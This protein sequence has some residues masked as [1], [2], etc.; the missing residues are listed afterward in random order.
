MLFTANTK[1]DEDSISI[2]D[3][4]DKV[5]DEKL[6]DK[7]AAQLREDVELVDGVHGK[8]DVANYL[9]G[10]VAP[11]FFGSAINNFGVKE[12][13]DTFI[14]VCPLPP[15]AARHLREVNVEEEKMSGF[16]FK[17]HA[18]LDPKHRDQDC[19]LFRVCSGRFERNKYFI[20]SGWTKTYTLV[21]PTPFMAR[22]KSII[23]DAYAG[24]WSV[25]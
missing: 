15:G 3:I 6:G 12:M 5:L 22:D 11:V 21:I 18:N 17:I 8:L 23:E 13:L 24:M 25:I 20:M 1:A 19:L 16:V 7:D 9:A 4:N 2:S 10:K 14:H